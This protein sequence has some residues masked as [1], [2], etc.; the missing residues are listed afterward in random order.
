MIKFRKV[1]FKNFLSTIPSDQASY[2]GYEIYMD[3]DSVYKDLQTI[4]AGSASF[5]SILSKLEEASKFK[6]HRPNPSQI[7]P[8]LQ[9]PTG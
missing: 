4:L 8:S 1:R 7:A 2:L 3:F 5:P 6:P 9:D